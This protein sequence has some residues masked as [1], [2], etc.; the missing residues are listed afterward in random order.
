MRPSAFKKRIFLILLFSPVVVWIFLV[1]KF[2]RPSQGPIAKLL[3]P[4]I[5]SPKPPAELEPLAA[6]P[7]PSRAMPTEETPQ[8]RTIPTEETLPARVFHTEW[9]E[10][11]GLDQWKEHRFSGESSYI[12]NR[13]DSGDIVL[14]ASSRDASSAIYKSVD[15]PNGGEGALLSWQWKAVKFPSGK[16]NKD[17]AAKKEND[18]VLRIYAIFKSVNPLMSETIQYVWDD[19]FPEGTHASSPSS[20]RVHVFVIESG[21]NPDG[22]WVEEVR[23]PVEDYEKLFGKK[24]VRPFAGI[25]IM[26]DSDNTQSESQGDVKNIKILIPD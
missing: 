20:D 26:S 24:P 21:P 15:I 5:E 8:V 2:Y 12:L 16:E 9:T 3:H 14:E 1:I 18:F 7:L 22:R 19:H 11:D 10:L 13:D 4:Q 23:N 6:E 17:F 25:G